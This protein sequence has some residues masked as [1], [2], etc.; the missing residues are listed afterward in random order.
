M[1]EDAELKPPEGSQEW[2][3]RAQ[4][5]EIKGNSLGGGKSKQE[6]GWDVWWGG[7]VG[8]LSSLCIRGVS[9]APPHPSKGKLSHGPGQCSELWVF[10][11]SPFLFGVLQNYLRRKRPGHR[12]VR[13]S[14]QIL[15]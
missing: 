6:M 13:F 10:V 15:P 14:A 8:T 3:R 4:V 11:G 12:E 1:Q 7:A 2:M 5:E 9:A